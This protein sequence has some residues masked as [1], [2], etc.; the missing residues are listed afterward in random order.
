MCRKEDRGKFD[1]FGQI[2]SDGYYENTSETVGAR[3]SQE[4]VKLKMQVR[5]WRRQ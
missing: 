5:S 4:L 1:M 2:T 3:S